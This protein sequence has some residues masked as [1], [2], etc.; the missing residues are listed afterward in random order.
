MFRQCQ[1]HRRWRTGFDRLTAFRAALPNRSSRRQANM[2]LGAGES[3]SLSCLRLLTH[4]R[5][6]CSVMGRL[7]QAWRGLWPRLPGRTDKARA[8]IL[9]VALWLRLAVKQPIPVPR[10]RLL[11]N[12]S[13]RSVQ[14]R[15]E[16]ELIAAFEVFAA[17]ITASH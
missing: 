7:A 6:L 5:F 12:G 17:T 2:W 11:V 16:G 10:L 4:T 9:A 15:E 8:G 3:G 13:M 14:V 1:S